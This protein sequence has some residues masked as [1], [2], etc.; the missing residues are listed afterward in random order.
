MRVPNNIPS[1]GARAKF[2]RQRLYLVTP[3]L[4]DPGTLTGE[5]ERALGAADV[6]ALG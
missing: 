4:D 2:N 5:L 3:T 6:A 1:P